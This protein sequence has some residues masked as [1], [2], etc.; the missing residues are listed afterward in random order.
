MD[1]EFRDQGVVE[2]NLYGDIYEV[3]SLCDVRKIKTCVRLDQKNKEIEG[4]MVRR[5]ISQFRCV[6][7]S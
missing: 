6:D 5:N 2:I 3:K 4:R 7:A 1:D